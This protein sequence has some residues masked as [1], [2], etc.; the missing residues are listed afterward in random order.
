MVLGALL[1]ALAAASL[2][3]FVAFRLQGEV[4]NIG[5]QTT[6]GL[7]LAA[8]ERFVPVSLS[9]DLFVNRGVWFK[10]LLF[11]QTRTDHR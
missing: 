10:A 1:G 2:A 3:I 11:A 6:D 5:L 8:R 7:L 9:Q 4:E